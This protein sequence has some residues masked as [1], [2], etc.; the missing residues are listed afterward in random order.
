MDRLFGPAR[1]QGQIK[2]SAAAA[3]NRPTDMTERETREV[4]DGRA[5][6]RTDSRRWE[7]MTPRLERAANPRA[8]FCPLSKDFRRNPASD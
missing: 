6:V 3:T 8:C 2:K 5:D 4:T 7:N 1:I